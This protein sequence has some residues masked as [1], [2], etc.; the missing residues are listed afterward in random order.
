MQRRGAAWISAEEPRLRIGDEV[1]PSLH[2]DVDAERR[3]ATLWTLMRPA[4]THPRSTVLARSH[5]HGKWL[6]WLASS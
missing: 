1:V 6:E 5:P 4:E 3:H 2:A